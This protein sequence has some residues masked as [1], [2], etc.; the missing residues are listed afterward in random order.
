MTQIV[1]AV[2]VKVFFYFSVPHFFL[3]PMELSKEDLEYE[4]DLE[5]FLALITIQKQPRKKQIIK[6]KSS[7]KSASSASA[8]DSD[9]TC[10]GKR[11]VK[12]RRKP[13]KSGG[14]EEKEKQ[15]S[16]PI[17]SKETTWTHEGI[18]TGLDTLDQAI[19]CTLSSSVL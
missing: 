16:A 6:K 19:A 10:L 3:L 15:A 9:S 13:R 7:K 2:Q 5:E 12:M 11:K 18:G 4:R 14:T 8:S 17:I 1:W